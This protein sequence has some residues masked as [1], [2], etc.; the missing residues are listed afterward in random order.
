MQLHKM[1]SEAKP[2]LTAQ[3]EKPNHYSYLKE[4][5]VEQCPLF[6]QHKCTQHRPFTC[7]H[8]HFM[9]QRRRRPVR[10]RDGSFNY[11]A[12]NYCTK[13]D[14]TTGLC[15]EGDEC[16]FLHRTAGDTERRYHLRYYKT[17]MCVH[18][19]DSRGFCVKNGPHCAFAHGNQDL[20]PPVYDIKEIQALETP[21]GDNAS[22]NGPNVLDKERN[23]MN[24]DPKW[25]DT[26]YVLSSYKTEACKRPPRLCRQ[27]Y[28]CPQYHNSRDKRRS[29]R[30]FKYRSTPCPDVR[31]GDEWGEPGNC[32]AGDLCGYCHTRTEQQ[33]HPEIYKSTKCND[34]QQAGYCPRGVFCAF[35]HV[36]QEMSIARELAA[37]LDAGTNLADILSNVLPKRDQKSSE[38]SN[39]SG[40]MS[41]CAS[42]SSLGS[43]SSSKAPGANRHSFCQQPQHEAIQQEILRKQLQAIDSD[44]LLDVLE[45]NQQ[46]QRLLVALNMTNHHSLNNH[47]NLIPLSPHFSFNPCE[48]LCESVVG[49]ALEDLHLDEPLGLVASIDRDFETDSPTVSNSISAG[50]A[51]S[52]ILG[53]SAP[54]N[55]PGSGHNSLGQFSPSAS[56]PLHHLHSGFLSASRFSHQD[57]LD[58]GGLF[59]NNIGHNHGLSSSAS[60]LGSTLYDFNMSPS[61]HSP[62]I[63]NF[64]VSP[65]VGS[66]S[67]DQGTNRNKLLSWEE[68][69]SQARVAWQ[70]ECEEAQRK[71]SIA[72]Q[73]RDEAISQA[74][75]L[76]Q[77]V[78]L[79]QGSPYLHGLRRISELRNLSLATLKSLQS[80]LRS[81]L[82]EIDKVLYL[83]TATKCMVCEERNRS[84][85]LGP[86]NHFVLCSVCAP[87]QQDCPYCQAPII[88]HTRSNLT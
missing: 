63:N 32:A 76:Q 27:G 83:Q 43:N 21:D 18:D 20:R 59:M 71:A 64:P 53:S 4:F 23:L 78:D 40:E 9:N 29:P 33:F 84:V 14:E 38:S 52:G 37:P 68:R 65:R 35:A 82:E 17:C 48:T 7:F 67:Y 87:Q 73:Q 55:I 66:G 49:N 50:L 2:L 81:D 25:Q 61:S 22:C 41:E 24:E 62:L 10:K 26:N 45:K 30:K 57:Q 60:K 74:K 16:P 39:G 56:S 72:E 70:R 12:D 28:A 19:T 1:P 77:E 75:A 44:P 51:S 34:V 58:S 31:H 80:Q 42:T 86:C 47:S 54:V 69:V 79:L 5:R 8:W 46:K 11:S 85:T 15:P 88:A 3:T 36:D 6:L 13:Y